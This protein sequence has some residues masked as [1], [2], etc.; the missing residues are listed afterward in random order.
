MTLA[1]L[2]RLCEECGCNPGDELYLRDV[3]A[4]MGVVYYRPGVFADRIIVDQGWALDAIYTVFMRNEEFQDDIDGKHGRFTR[5]QLER[6]F[7]KERGHS[8]ADQRAFLSFMEQCGICFRTEEGYSTEYEGEY[9][10][11]DKLDRWG[12]E[13]ER[14]FR[15]QLSDASGTEVTVT[16]TLL[17]DGI[18]RGFLSKI[19]S[20]AGYRA[21]YWRY[22]CHFHDRATECEVLIRTDGNAIRLQAW[23]EKATEVLRTL[24]EVLEKLS[25]GHPP[26]IA[27]SEPPAEPIRIGHLDPDEEPAERLKPSKYGPKSVFFSYRHPHPEHPGSDRGRL[28]LRQLRDLLEAKEWKVLLDEQR[29]QDGDSISEFITDVRECGFLVPVFCGRYLDSRYTLSELFTFRQKWGHDEPAF[30]DRTA[31][32]VYP[33]SRIDDPIRRAEYVEACRK[34]AS[35]YGTPAANLSLAPQDYEQAYNLNSWGNQLSQILA[36]LTDRLHTPTAEAVAERL[37][38]QFERLHPSRTGRSG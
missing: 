37:N 23:G 4:L 35:G 8:A 18:A 36:A 27:C 13:H 29:L 16:F 32:V 7:W 22:G 33:E 3:L 25:S 2:Q 30:A 24:V 6:Y 26:T 11:P 28:L 14:Q 17:H 19:G 9:I 34:M 10:I 12:P 38:R 21:T 15:R 31:C 20:V 5:K 1:D